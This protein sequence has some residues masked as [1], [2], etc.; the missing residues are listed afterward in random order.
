[1]SSHATN[2]YR[3]STTLFPFAWRG[4]LTRLLWAVWAVALVLGG[5]HQITKPLSDLLLFLR[6]A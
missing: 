6:N 4:R 3:D 1:M 2:E 5:D